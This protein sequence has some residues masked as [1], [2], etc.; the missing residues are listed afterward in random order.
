MNSPK[1]THK[2]RTRWL[3]FILIFSLILGALLYWKFTKQTITTAAKQGT[4]IESVYGVGTVTARQIFQA[5][6]GVPLAL[7]KITVSEGDRVKQGQ[8]LATFDDGAIMKAPFDGTVTA[9]YYRTGELV[10]PQSPVLTVLNTKDIYLE[11]SLEQQAAL[12]VR[13][14]QS[15]IATFESIRNERFIGKVAAIFP[16]ENQFIVRIEFEKL[17]ENLL[18]A[19]T[20]DV[21]IEIAKKNSVVLVPFAAVQSG[22]VTL[23]RDGKKLRQEVTLGAIDGDWAEVVKGDVKP[24]DLIVTKKQ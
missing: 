17:P 21:A 7:K 1:P 23:I 6:T 4:I 12:R 16:K 8:L 13:I 2:S 5:R 3:L 15:A 11:V 10:Q 24:D 19:M 20:A 18:P 22:R 9:I 14:D